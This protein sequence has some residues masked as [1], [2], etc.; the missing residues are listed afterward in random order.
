MIPKISEAYEDFAPIS[1]APG[2]SQGTELQVSGPGRGARR[3]ADF[4]KSE[5]LKNS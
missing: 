4:K 5:Y 2:E 3:T 1:G